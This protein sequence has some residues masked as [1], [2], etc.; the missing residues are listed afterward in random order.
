MSD[1]KFPAEVEQRAISGSVASSDHVVCDVGGH[2]IN[3]GRSP[4]ASELKR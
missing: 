1:L 4:R 3:G 2:E